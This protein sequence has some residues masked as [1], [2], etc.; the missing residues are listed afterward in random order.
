MTRA[1]RRPLKISSTRAVG[2]HG[3]APRGCIPCQSGCMAP[4][5]RANQ[6]CRARSHSSYFRRAAPASAGCL[7]AASSLRTPIVHQL[8]LL[9]PNWSAQG[10]KR[11]M[12][13][14][15]TAKPPPPEDAFVPGSEDK[16]FCFAFRSSGSMQDIV[17]RRQLPAGCSSLSLELRS[18]VLR[19]FRRH[20]H[21]ESYTKGARLPP[22]PAAPPGAAR[23][24]QPASGSTCP[25][26][27]R[28][29]GP[30]PAMGP[31][32]LLPAPG[33]L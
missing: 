29:S 22:V 16:K 19:V 27:G 30:R 18:G 25:S 24:A 3:A 31:R 7:R 12:Q 23:S 8:L 32:G 15:G 26:G 20:V 13:V 1:G 14:H 6:L 21:Q 5:R 11:G 10:V 33:H 4:V 17:F 28:G 2:I 9:R